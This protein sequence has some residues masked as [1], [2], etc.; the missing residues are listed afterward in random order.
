[1]YA[2]AHR[3]YSSRFPENTLLAFEQAI[4]AGTDFI[5]TDLRLSREGVIVCSHD[6][7]LVRLL[8][9][10][11]RI[12]DLDVPAL[13]AIDTGDGKGIPTLEEVLNLAAGRVGVF[14][15]VKITSADMVDLILDTL[16]RHPSN[17]NIVFG[18]RLIEQ[19]KVLRRHDSD[20]FVIGMI[21]DLSEAP[22][23]IE[24]GARGIRFW[25]ED[26]VE[27]Q[28]KTVHDAGCEVLVTAGL[29]SQGETTGNINKK[30]LQYLIRLG[31]DG[32]LVNNPTLVVRE[33]M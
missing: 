26:L 16:S 30:R 17:D 32:V 29:R 11:E 6:D 5:E 1:M 9:R 24:L 31:I 19:L 4:L 20:V 21:R 14:L 12:E 10:E 8:G 13:K 18:A 25:E 15:D 22:L 7:S 28:V 33:R 2:I 27:A 3:G 23:F